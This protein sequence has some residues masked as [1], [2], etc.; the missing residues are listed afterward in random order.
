MSPKSPSSWRNLESKFGVKNKKNF[1]DVFGVFAMSVWRRDSLEIAIPEAH[2]EICPPLC[3]YFRPEQ[4]EQ[5]EQTEHAE[6]TEANRPCRL[7]VASPCGVFFGCAGGVTFFSW[8]ELW[9]EICAR[10]EELTERTHLLF[11]DN[12]TLI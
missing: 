6:Q 11:N 3:F 8:R 9:Q 4:T 10:P 7:C 12:E 1:F 2:P 5:T